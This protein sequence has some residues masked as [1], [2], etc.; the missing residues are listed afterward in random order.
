MNNQRWHRALGVDDL[1]YATLVGDPPGVADL[2]ARLRVERR[3]AKD[4]FAFFSHD[5]AS[6]NRATRD[7]AH[8]LR[9]DI[10]LLVAEKCHLQWKLLIHVQVLPTT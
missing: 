8:D 10:E 2:T 3:L 5:H 6:D 4:Y 1:G 7:H 9:G